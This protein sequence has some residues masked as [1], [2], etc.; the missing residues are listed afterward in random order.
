MLQV[1]AD[2]FLLAVEHLEALLRDLVASVV[3][4]HESDRGS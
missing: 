4:D 1:S 3:Q 2:R